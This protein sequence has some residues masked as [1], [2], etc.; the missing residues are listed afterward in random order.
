MSFWTKEGV[1]WVGFG[2][3]TVAFAHSAAYPEK[4]GPQVEV[5]LRDPGEPHPISVMKAC[6]NEVIAKYPCKVVLGFNKLESFDAFMSCL[7]EARDE[8]ATA[9]AVTSDEQNPKK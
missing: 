6:P 4:N 8:L 7:Q 3:G 1:Q 9:L 2:A 5:Q